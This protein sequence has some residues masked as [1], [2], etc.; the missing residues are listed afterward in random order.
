MRWLTSMRA[1]VTFSSND[2]GGTASAANVIIQRM[3]H[4]T[5]KVT[6][7]VVASLLAFITCSAAQSSAIDTKLAS[8]Y[9]Q[10][11]K[12]TSDRDSGKTWGLPL[13]GPMMFVDPR[14]GNV[15]A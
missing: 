10:Q 5:A 1:S 15:V 11:L 12:Q 3:A 2:R 13:Y 9:F 4:R 8:Q 14:S 6:F 7:R